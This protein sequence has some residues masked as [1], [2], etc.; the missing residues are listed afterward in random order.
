MLNFRISTMNKAVVQKSHE[1]TSWDSTVNWRIY[2]LADF[3]TVFRIPSDSL[4]YFESAALNDDSI[5]RFLSGAS[6]FQGDHTWMGCYLVSY[7]MP[8]ESV[9]KV[10]ISHYGGFFYAPHE[11]TFYQIEDAQKKEWLDYLSDKYVTMP[12]K[13]N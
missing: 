4:I 10:I 5:H 12:S 6:K 9:R 13:T 1:P 11:H 2:K 7:K 8:D 3:K